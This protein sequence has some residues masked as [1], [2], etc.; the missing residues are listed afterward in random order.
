MTAASTVVALLGIVTLAVLLLRVRSR[1][2]V[3]ARNLASRQRE[4]D[5]VYAARL[6]VIRDREMA[7]WPQLARESECFQEAWMRLA[8]LSDRGDRPLWT[9]SSAPPSR[10]LS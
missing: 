6:T 3:M 2:N 10:Q 1:L 5:A 4:L 8:E 7:L 9:L